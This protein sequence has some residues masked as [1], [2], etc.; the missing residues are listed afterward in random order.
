MS[1]IRVSIDEKMLRDLMAGHVVTAPKESTN[2]VGDQEL[3]LSLKDIGWDRME[4]ALDDAWNQREGVV[5]REGPKRH[6]RESHYR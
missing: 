4:K 1:D 3:Q 5:R 2:L 6:E